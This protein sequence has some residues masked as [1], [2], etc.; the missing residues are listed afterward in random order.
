MKLMTPLIL[1]SGV[2]GTSPGLLL[3]AARAGAGAV[4]AKSCS[5]NAREG[6]PNPVAL[7]WEHGIINAIGLTNP[8]ASV[9]VEELVE[10]RRLLQELGVPLIANIFGGTP[11]EYAEAARKISEAHPDMIEV[12]ISCPNVKDEF[13]TP[14]SGSE[15]TAAAVTLAVRKVV[16]LP[17]SVKLSPNVPD[18]GSIARAVEEAGADAITAINTMPGRLI[19]AESRSAVLANRSGGI[20]GPALKPIA[21]HCVAQVF[22]RCQLPIIGTGG[23]SN[24]RD[25]IEMIMAGATAVGIG[26]AVYYRGV[27]AFQLI[28]DEMVEFLRIEGITTV[29]DIIGIAA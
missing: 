1:A 20:S 18:V 13:G 29:R 15:R 14:F 3:Q 5:I 22:S 26:S 19:N 17:I 2:I 25:A 27:E 8:G 16:D 11:D 21:L 12:N 24:G 6:H 7:E 28:H 23:V 4:T 10:A 9:E